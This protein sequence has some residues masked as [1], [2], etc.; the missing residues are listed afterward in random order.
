MNSSD[1]KL[2]IC[3][4]I[5]SLANE[6][7]TRVLLNIV[8]H[9][10]RQLFNISIYTLVS[11]K[12]STLLSEFNCLD[13]ALEGK[14]QNEPRSRSEHR[15]KLVFL[16]TLKELRQYVRKER[17]DL[18]HAHCPRSLVYMVGVQRNVKKIYTAHIFPGL[19]T[20]AL[21]GPLKGRVIAALINTLIKFIDLPIAC[22]KSVS[23]EYFD[24]L[25]LTIRW[26]NNGI[27]PR[28][29]PELLSQRS[30]WRKT[31]GFADDVKYFLYIGRLSPEKGPL[32]LAKIFDA[33][34]A[35]DYHLIL[36]GDGPEL[37]KITAMRYKNVRVEGFKADISAYLLC[38]DVYVSPSK[39]EGLANTLLEAMSA[40]IPLLL[41]DIPSHRMILAEAGT[42]IGELF[43]PNDP[44]QI[45]KKMRTVTQLDRAETAKR[46]QATFEKSY[47]A[48]AMTVGYSSLYT[49]ITGFRR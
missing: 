43:D 10:D 28:L 34:S 29:P 38:C 1:R 49:E 31:L 27:E 8:R 47:T 42:Q 37:S 21:Y 48:A 20:I 23:D 12:K 46:A 33:L 45:V 6:G 15:C 17:I 26:V 9:L 13:L 7:P 22:S 5:S 41:S 32:E 35:A 2:N 3:F 36:V 25:G 18:I 4:L 11:E 16:Q 19:Q 30:Q 44:G 39:T 14:A 24:N 40:G